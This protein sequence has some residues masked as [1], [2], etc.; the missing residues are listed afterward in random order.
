[1][2]VADYLMSPLPTQALS[3]YSCFPV[4]ARCTSTMH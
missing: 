1:M 4:V 3:M 2:R